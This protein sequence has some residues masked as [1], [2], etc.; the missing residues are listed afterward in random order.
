MGKIITFY[1]YKGGVGRTMCL[2]NI[3]VILAKWKYRTLIVDWDLEAPGLEH[4]YSGFI[5]IEQ[6]QAQKGVIDLLSENNTDPKAVSWWKN[7]IVNI[8]LPDTTVPL[9]LLTAGNRNETYY[10]MVRQFDVKNFYSQKNGGEIIEEL[11]SQW[12]AEY[13]FVLV[14]SRTG[15]TDIGGICTVQLPEILVMLFTATEQ[16]FKGIRSVAQRAIEAKKRMGFNPVNLTILPVPTRIDNTENDL[17]DQWMDKFDKGLGPVYESWLPKNVNSGHFLFRTKVPYIPFYSFG[18]G[19]AV[20][21]RKSTIDTAGIGYACES[22]AA[23]LATGLNY[24]G[25]AVDNR[26]KLISLAD[27]RFLES[28]L[29]KLEPRIKAI[30]NPPVINELMALK[31]DAAPITPVLLDKKSAPD[32][33]NQRLNALMAEKAAEIY[34]EVS[35]YDYEYVQVMRERIERKIADVIKQHPTTG[36]TSPEYLSETIKEVIDHFRHKIDTG[37]DRFSRGKPTVDGDIKMATSQRGIRRTSIAV[38]I[39]VL[40]AFIVVLSIFLYRNTRSSGVE[41]EQIDSISNKL[42][43]VLLRDS[44]NQ[45]L[46]RNDTGTAIQYLDR[47]VTA[48]RQENDTAATIDLLKQQLRLSRD[49][50]S[51]AS[52]EKSTGALEQLLKTQVYRVDIFYDRYTEGSEE[53]ANRVVLILSN[54]KNLVIR[55]KSLRSDLFKT[56]YR[57]SDNTI[58][59]NKKEEKIAHSIMEQVR[60]NRIYMASKELRNKPNQSNYLSLFI[61]GPNSGIQHQQVLTE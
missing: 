45:A 30:L 36:Q 15:I 20:F 50:D 22:I 16:G 28:I 53:L 13:D 9:H 60:S 5:D 55:K 34:N 44:A 38:L 17:T 49:F 42:Q 32:P 12:K 3:A 29:N 14:D 33:A 18:E 41:V 58:V 37:R 24:P 2:A 59:Y 46:D 23:L 11:R 57:I 47:A 39:G 25:L 6:A 27:N 51:L 7:A 43:T 21:D 31:N 35:Y 61:K 8:P 54:E 56:K 52:P 48:S 10:T 26:D 40:V 1:S 19:L 4:F